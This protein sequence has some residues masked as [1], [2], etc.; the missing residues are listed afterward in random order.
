MDKENYEKEEYNMDGA[1]GATQAATLAL[2]TDTA[3][4]GNRGYGIGMG[5]GEGGGYGYSGGLFANHS[6][7]QHGIANTTQAVEN[8]A[9]CTREVLKASMDSNG[10]A[11]DA[12]TIQTSFT[13]ICDRIAG[14]EAQTARDMLQLTRDGN[15]ARAEAAK[16][17]CDVKVQAANDKAEMLAAIAAQGA[18]TI[19]REL[20]LANAKITQLET[21]NALSNRHHGG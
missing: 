5:G 10:R 1:V 16:C 14:M 3:R 13:R 11:F 18:A 20:N 12:A 17:C 9:D 15:D 4:A 21:V 19:T 6:S 8:Q 7:I 2:L